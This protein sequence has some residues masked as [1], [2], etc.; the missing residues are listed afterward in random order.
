MPMHNGFLPREGFCADVLIKVVRNTALNPALILPL[1][2]LARFTKQGQ[3]LSILHPTALGKIKTLLYLGLARV[4]ANWLSDQTVN[5]WT[6]DKYD[7][8]KEIVLV[9]GGASGIGAQ[10]VKL[11]EEKGITVVVLDVQPLSYTAS[12]KVHYYQCDIRSMDKIAAVAEEIRATVGHPTVV[13]NNAGVARGKTVLDSQPGDIRFTF[14]V[15]TFAHYWMAK[16]FL[17]NMI[18]NNHGMFV[19]VASVASWLTI[20]NMVDYGASKAAALSFHEG[21]TAELTTRYN[22]PKVRTVIVHPGHT[23]TPLF[24]GYDQNTAFVMPTLEPESIAE[25]IV[26]QVLSGRSGRV[27]LPKIGS[28]FASL[29][30]NADF[31]QTYVRAGGESYMAKFN[32]HQV[33]KDVDASY[34]GKES[35]GPSESTVLVSKD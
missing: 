35:G 22:A 14:D 16:V 8:S 27:V 29:R 13:I 31:Y 15:N 33:I 4:A 26:R 25:G 11:L 24:A 19:T 9:T 1:V 21:I 18:A 28:I 23:K 30:G 2:L 17:P 34:E 20:P 7:W 3:D 6:N 5:N 10:I 32:G 12:S